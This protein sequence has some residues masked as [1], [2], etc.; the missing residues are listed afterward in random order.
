[1]PSAAGLVRRKTFWKMT[2]TF[3]P[4]V[5]GA[6]LTTPFLNLIP[7]FV[8]IKIATGLLRTRIDISIQQCL[9]YK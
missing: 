5:S 4:S 8:K 3:Y 6:G 2:S 7:L 1:M 9:H